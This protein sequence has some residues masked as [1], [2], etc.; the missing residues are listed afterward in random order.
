MVGEDG[1]VGADF[2]EPFALGDPAAPAIFEEGGG[3]SRVGVAEF[4]VGEVVEMDADQGEESVGLAVACPEDFVV[5][6][7]VVPAEAFEGF[8]LG[9][10]G[11]EMGFEPLALLAEEV[12][13]LVDLEFFGE[14]SNGAMEDVP[15]QD[16]GG[17]EECSPEDECH[18]EAPGRSLD[19]SKA[20]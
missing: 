17:G 6:V 3:V 10:G 4:G 7:G 14:L 1:L 9:E 11:E 19:K 8:V 2:V 13:G 16:E 18:G 20:V 5:P 12:A 15:A